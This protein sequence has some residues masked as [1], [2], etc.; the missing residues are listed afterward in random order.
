VLK[1]ILIKSSTLKKEIII[2]CVSL[3]MAI[4]INIYAII[5]YK[6]NWSELLT[7]LPI[8]LLVSVLI[9]LLIFV[10]RGITNTVL[11]LIKNKN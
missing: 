7:Q 5:K 3:L 9:Y 1:D 6:A 8:V 4:A 2:W 10:L 11:K